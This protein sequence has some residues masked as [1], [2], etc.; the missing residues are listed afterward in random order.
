MFSI[1]S[2]RNTYGMIRRICFDSSASLGPQS[3]E[4]ELTSRCN[5]RCFFCSSHS[6][7]IPHSTQNK[8][9]SSETLEQLATSLSC[10]KTKSI[11]FA[12]S[13]EPFL[14]D[15]LLDFV[16]SHGR[17]FDIR[18]LTNGSCLDKVDRQLFS[19]IRRLAVS[20]N[21]MSE[22]RH[23][24]IH[25]YSGCSQLRSILG[26]IIRLKEYQAK[27]IKLQ[28]NVVLCRKNFN[29]LSEFMSFSLQENIP[30]LI[31]PLCANFDAVKSDALSSDEIA[32]GLH[33]AK[34][35]F[36]HVGPLSEN[37]IFTLKYFAYFLRL[38]HRLKYG[39]AKG[40]AISCLSGFRNAYVDSSGNLRLCWHRTDPIGNINDTNFE[41][42]WSS[43]EAK[44][45]RRCAAM[46]SFGA[47]PVCSSCFGCAEPHMYSTHFLNRY[48]RKY[49]YLLSLYLQDNN[50]HSLKIENKEQTHKL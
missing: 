21:S 1:A 7:L 45:L 20:C 3:I 33:Y 42:L 9:F 18:I 38:Y 14:S 49:P 12:G 35:A 36:E 47:M 15:A 44:Y 50:V 2:I 10:F 43:I 5:H 17:S 48:I 28:M 31:R 26:N 13:G 19:R 22:E 37:Y 40:Q 46:M 29:E 4:I 30:V 8:Y 34:D 41:K 27:E 16:Q 23:K 39:S 11:L 24:E 25:G 32:R 6:Y